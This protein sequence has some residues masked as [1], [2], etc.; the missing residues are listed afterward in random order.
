MLSGICDQR[1]KRLKALEGL[2]LLFCSRGGAS[3]D[4][5]RQGEDKEKRRCRVEEWPGSPASGIHNCE[6]RVEPRR[7]FIPWI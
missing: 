4:P 7:Q 6:A 5:N 2:V 3:F 1:L